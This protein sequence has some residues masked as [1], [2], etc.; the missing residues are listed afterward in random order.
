MADLSDTSN[1]LVSFI[2]AQ[3]YPNGTG[4]PSATGLATKIFAGWP[5]SATLEADLKA[6][7]INISVY[8]QPNVE[9]ITS[10]YPRNWSDQTRVAATITG[11]VTGSTITVGGTIT[12]GNYITAAVRNGAYSYLV[13]A[14]DTLA[15]IATA[16]AALI[17]VDTPATATGAVI[18][19]PP[20][21]GGRITIRTGAPGTSIQEIRRQQRGYQITIWAP[22][23]DARIATASIV[24]P[25]L[26]GTDFLPLPDTTCTW[27]T[28][29]GSNDI[30]AQ[31][32][33]GLYRRDIFYWCE[34][35]TTI[36]TSAN[37]ITSFQA[38]VTPLPANSP[39]FQLLS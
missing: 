25:A 23:N 24:D 10:R 9:R 15:T 14:N 36:V 8:P 3:I 31:E 1:A 18:T 7:T 32:L 35:P 17:N 21:S 5:I 16:L 28:Y 12:A 19:L 13:Q 27:L 30:D 6:G 26:A 11:T 2:A 29:K 33:K 39:D 22:S 34:Y 20:T 37:P 4:Q 38:P